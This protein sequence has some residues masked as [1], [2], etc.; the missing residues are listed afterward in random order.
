MKLLDCHL[1]GA[2]VKVDNRIVQATCWHCVIETMWGA[3]PKT[4]KK[5]IGYPKGW[6]FMNLF[7]HADGTVY[8]KGVEDTNLKGTLPPTEIIVKPK[9]TAKQKA[10]EKA[11]LAEK[12]GKLKKQLKGES[13]R[14][15]QKKLESQIRKLQTK[16]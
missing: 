6:R 13:R 10:E 2:D 8:H 16:L 1:C 3:A 14:T 4:E 7:V 5:R 12:I 11:Q 15:Q 9:K